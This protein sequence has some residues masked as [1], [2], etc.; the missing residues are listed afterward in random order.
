MAVAVTLANA[1]QLAKSQAAEQN[2]ILK[3][4]FDAETQ[5]IK[6][7]HQSWAGEFQKAEQQRRKEEENWRKFYA[8]V[9]NNEKEWYH[10]TAMLALNGI[11]LWALKQQYE[12]QKEI[13]DKTYELANRQL[14]LAEK[15]FSAY[16]EQFQPH[17]TAMS[18]QITNY[19]AKPYRPQYD[20]TAGRFALNARMKMVG[21]RR[22]VLMC[23]SSYCTGAT[24]QALQDLAI[25]EAN[26]VG[27]A[28]NSAIRYEKSREVNMEKKW[29]NA[30]LAF[31]QAGRDV[32][33]QGITGIDG[34]VRA[35]HSFGADPGAALSQL[36]GTVAY[37]VGG[38]IPDQL[39]QN[40]GSVRGGSTPFLYNTGA[41]TSVSRSY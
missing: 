9:Y 34:A 6:A 1:A 27:N 39:G 18:Q 20:I 29:L 7:N 24:A 8:D 3:E 22:E 12:Q 2:K 26:L 17:E 28:M 25:Q 40:G 4:R 35:F 11:Q 41:S 30:R 38:I 37:T 14:Q 23:S 10:Y 33:S 15:M 21:K 19:F 36:L 5:K 32:S 13:A 16:K 31:V